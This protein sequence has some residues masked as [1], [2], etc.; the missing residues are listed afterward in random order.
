MFETTRAVVD[1]T[2]AGII[3]VIVPH[4]GA[5]LPGLVQ[6]VELAAPLFHCEDAGPPISMAATMK[7]LH[8][9][10]AGA[11]V[12]NLLRELLDWADPD[13]IHYGSDYP[14]TPAEAAERL[15]AALDATPLIDDG[16][17]KKVMRDNTARLFPRLTE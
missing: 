16:L 12:P 17:R 9:D 5:A 3:R 15:R 14:F 11:P 7:Q 2:M 10:L 1:M 13:R 4:A 6:R 8:F